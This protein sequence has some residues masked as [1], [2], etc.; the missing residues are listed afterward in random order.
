MSHLSTLIQ[1]V[2]DDE[3]AFGYAEKEH[4]INLAEYIVTWRDYSKL[5]EREAVA[6]LAKYR[7][8]KLAD[9]YH[10]QKS[11]QLIQQELA[12]PWTRR[13]ARCGLPISSEKSLRTGFGSVCRRKVCGEESKKL[14]KMRKIGLTEADCWRFA[15]TDV[16]LE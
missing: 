5:E 15:D 13:C 9:K 2:R 16:R 14:E 6:I 3:A 8:W 10:R 11:L 12:K 7:L 1:R 4:L